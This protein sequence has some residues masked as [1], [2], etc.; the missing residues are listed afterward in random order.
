MEDLYD[1]PTDLFCAGM[2]FGGD[3]VAVFS[4]GRYHP[5]LKMSP[6]HWHDYG[7]TDSCDGYSYYDD[8]VGEPEGLQP[9][10]PSTNVRES[11]DDD[12][13]GHAVEFLRRS[14]KL[15][16]HELGHLYGLDHCVHNRCLM[17]GTGHL[18]EDFK[19]PSHLCGVC[20]RKLQWRLGFD[21]AER[22]RLL[23]NVFR[24]SMGMTKEADWCEKQCS[25]L[26]KR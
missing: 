25:R 24:E 1:G 7:Y 15:L 12:G 6:S 8:D 2:A 3:K 26:G 19:A 11:D 23:G 4:L 21:V 22:Y 10:P 17:M 18:V 20:L 9:N 14:G 13:G 16:T 5:F